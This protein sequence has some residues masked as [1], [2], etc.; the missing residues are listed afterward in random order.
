MVEKRASIDS[1]SNACYTDLMGI[2]V[3]G[4]EPPSSNELLMQLVRGT[5]DVHIH[6]SSPSFAE[7]RNDALRTANG[8]F[9]TPVEEPFWVEEEH[10][11][12]FYA[13]HMS[14]VAAAE[15]YGVVLPPDTQFRGKIA[16]AVL[17]RDRFWNGFD[18]DISTLSRRDDN[19]EWLLFERPCLSAH[20]SALDYSAK[21]QAAHASYEDKLCQVIYSVI[22]RTFRKPEVSSAELVHLAE[23]PLLQLQ[24]SR[25]FS[26]HQMETLVGFRNTIFRLT[27][28]YYPWFLGALNIDKV[29]KSKAMLT[30]ADKF[31]DEV[32]PR[33]KELNI[34]STI[35]DGIYSA[36]GTPEFEKTFNNRPS[37]SP[38][39]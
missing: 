6:P 2:W 33:I 14:L 26:E 17:Y 4:V 27:G 32:P 12:N 38:T 22:E 16:G 37:Y 15:E 35:E 24:N 39:L 29:A 30:A 18:E 20:I 3:V 31:Y 25:V 13:I 28:K 9:S 19:A 21:L 7:H 11:T 36:D 5:S 10:A 34:P 8:N 1:S 23:S